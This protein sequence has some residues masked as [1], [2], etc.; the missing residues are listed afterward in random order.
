MFLYNKL[1]NLVL[2]F[3]NLTLSCHFVNF[4]LFNGGKYIRQKIMKK[5]AILYSWVM[6]M[7]VLRYAIK[8]IIFFCSSLNSNKWELLFLHFCHII[9]IYIYTS[10]IVIQNSH[11][12]NCLSHRMYYIFNHPIILIIHRKNCYQNSISKYSMFLQMGNIF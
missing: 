1:P 10:G 2:C 6:M 4:I 8:V 12:Q 7:V 11:N 9:Y 5:I 3:C